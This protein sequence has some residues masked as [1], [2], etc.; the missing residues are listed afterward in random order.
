[1]N[2]EKFSIDGCSYGKIDMECSKRG[3]KEAAL[4]NKKEFFRRIK[5]EGID[6]CPCPENCPHHGNCY[7]C[8]CLH[9]AHRDHLP[10]C[11]WSMVNDRIE[12]LAHM[13]ESSVCSNVEIKK[14]GDQNG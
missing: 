5:D 9:R 4:K 8:V 13:T 12:T 14:G 2:K 10:Y 6:H 1:M 3:D 7:E 11:F